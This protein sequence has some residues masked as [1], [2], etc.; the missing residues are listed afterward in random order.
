VP[1]CEADPWRRQ[2]FEGI[3]CPPEVRITTED[4]DAY[5]WYPEHRWVYDKLRL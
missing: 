3:P 1:F 2:Y 5:E 4:P